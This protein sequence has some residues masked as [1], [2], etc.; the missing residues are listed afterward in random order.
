M[1]VLWG[2]E[3]MGLLELDPAAFADKPPLWSPGPS[4]A[5]V[6]APNRW[7]PNGIYHKIFQTGH[8]AG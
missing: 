5:T 1:G 6:M 3:L 4:V 7:F 2:A 8:A